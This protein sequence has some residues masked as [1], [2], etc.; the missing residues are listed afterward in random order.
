MPVRADDDRGRDHGAGGG[1][2]ADLVD[3]DDAFQA[4]APEA[5]LEPE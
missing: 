1:S 5:A 4:V 2:D 3:P